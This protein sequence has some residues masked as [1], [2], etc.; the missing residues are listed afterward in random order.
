MKGI[1][2]EQVSRLVVL[3]NANPAY[4]NLLK[5]FFA[6]VETRWIVVPEAA[7][8]LGRSEEYISR[9]YNELVSLGIMLRSTSFCLTDLGRAVV[10]ELAR[11]FS[12]KEVRDGRSDQRGSSS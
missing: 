12:K 10:A 2:Q 8:A 5:L 1:D 7:K 9:I 11:T 3:V 4:V 6:E